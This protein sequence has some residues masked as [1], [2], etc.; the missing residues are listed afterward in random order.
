MVPFQV[1]KVLGVVVPGTLGEVIGIV[2]FSVVGLMVFLV[3]LY[4]TSAEKK[5]RSRATTWFGIALLV[6]TLV[7][8]VWGYLAI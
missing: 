5:A 3:P 8:T 2:F 1:L 6:G 4:D 7:F